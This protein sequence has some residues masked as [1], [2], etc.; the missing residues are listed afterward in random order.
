VTD[1]NSQVSQLATGDPK[2]IL[3]STQANLE[4]L[5]K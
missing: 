4:A 1:F 3:E 2:A 5:L